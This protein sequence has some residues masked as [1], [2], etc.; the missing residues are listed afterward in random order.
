MCAARQSGSRRLTYDC[1]DD[2]DWHIRGDLP[3]GGRLT[4]RAALVIGAVAAL[5]APAAGEPGDADR[6]SVEAP[7]L[8]NLERAALEQALEDRGLAI[9]PEPTGKTVGRIHAVTLPVF[10]PGDGGF[11]RRF[12]VFHWTTDEEVLAREVLLRPG[13]RWDPEVVAETERKLRDPRLSTV[14]VVVPVQSGEPGR[15]DLLVVTRDIWSLRPNLEWELQGSTLS[16]FTVG[17]VENNLFGWRKRVSVI[18]EMDLGSYSVGPG[19]LDTNLLGTQMYLLTTGRA[20]FERGGGGYEGTRSATTFGAPLWS[21]RDRWGWELDLF[22]TDLIAR[23]FQGDDLLLHT[24]PSGTELPHEYRRK[25]L[26]FEADAVH[27]VGDDIKYHLSA[28]Y[29]LELLRTELS[30]DFPG[31]AADRDWYRDEVME[32]PEDISSIFGRYRLFTPRFTRYRGINSFDLTEDVKLGPDIIGEVAM[33]M[34]PLGSDENFLG[35]STTGSFTFDWSGDGYVRLFAAMSGRLQEGDF[36]DNLVE[37]GGFAASPLV[38][39]NVRVV[40]RAQLAARLDETSNRFFTVGGDTGLRGYEIGEFVGE[41]LVLG[42]LELRSM[43]AALGSLRVGGVA[44][45]DLG[46]AAD[47]FDD[48]SIKHDLG[49]GVRVLI[50]QFS[51]MVFRLDWAVPLQ[52][53]RGPLLGRITAGLGQAFR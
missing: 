8:G 15:V 13:E 25:S 37:G 16:Y 52:G 45:W 32:R 44:F 42:N 39:D 14:A 30:P 2:L 28:G 4:L 17:L 9:D 43:P 26:F 31:S 50:P 6:E 40:V 12:N 24:A 33:A 29:R 22:H 21:L 47:T 7:E 19:Y 49:V 36:I 20:I 10:A 11:L 27:Q 5:A 35:L 38:G 23:E 41:K 53:E 3:H 18:Y 1:A 46:H 51:S 34:K 48:L